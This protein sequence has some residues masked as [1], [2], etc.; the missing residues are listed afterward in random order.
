MS[1]MQT[2]PPNTKRHPPYERMPPPPPL[3]NKHI[4]CNRG[5]GE[6]IDMVGKLKQH[7]EICAYACPYCML[8][9]HT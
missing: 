9:I 7:L 1:V 4:K 2:T 8:F 6:K 3:H 5:Q